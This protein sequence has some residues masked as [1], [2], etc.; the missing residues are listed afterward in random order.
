[1]TLEGHR[2]IVKSLAIARDDGLIASGGG[3]GTVRLWEARSG[4]ALSTIDGHKN[5][6]YGLCFSPIETA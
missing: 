5:T 2:G 4:A 1:M 6:V 3:D